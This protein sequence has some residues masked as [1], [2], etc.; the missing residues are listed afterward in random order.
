AEPG[1]APEAA[2]LPE[3]HEVPTT[4]SR[5]ARPGAARPP[6][7]V[8]QPPNGG[9]ASPQ[10]VIVTPGGQPPPRVVVRTVAAVPPA[11]PAPPPPPR[12]RWRSE[13]GLNLR[14][15][16]VSLGRRQGAAEEAGMGGVGLS[17]R[18]RPVPSFAIDFGVDA[19]GGIDYNGFKRSE[20]PISLSGMLFVNPRSRVQFYFMGGMH[21]SHAR[22]ERT[23]IIP[24]ATEGDIDTAV[25]SEVEYDYFG[26]HGGLGLEFRLSR[27]V[28][29]N[30][31][32]MAFIRERT[33]DNPEPEFVDLE[34]GRTTNTSGG[35][36]FRG[37]LTFYW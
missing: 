36:L 14:L 5:P 19:V 10:I 31:D 34:T 3:A 4:R 26:G 27:R 9:S 2:P 6:V 32:A 30:L 33:D 13:W 12:Y 20:I 1:A 28:A 17:L 7:V 15:Q 24:A 37:G 29:L 25:M 8:Y 11:P 18:Y 22:V 35:G 16:G 21:V 23:T